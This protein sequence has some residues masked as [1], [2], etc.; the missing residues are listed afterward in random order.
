MIQDFLPPKGIVLYVYLCIPSQH[1]W[2]QRRA[3]HQSNLLC[4][5]TLFYR[6]PEIHLGSAIHWN[7]IPQLNC[8]YTSYKFK[9][10]YLS[11]S[12]FNTYPYWIA[13]YYVDSVR[14][15]GTWHFWQHTDVGKVPGIKG[16]VDLNVFNGT[17]EELMRL[18]LP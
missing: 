7:I 11:D 6:H 10:R 14:Y 3:Q 9:E 1:L 13:H 4:A 15:K 12:I 17:L 2:H 8:L 16:S 18:T 5:P